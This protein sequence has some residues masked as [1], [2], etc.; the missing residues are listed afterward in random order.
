MAIDFDEELEPKVAL[1]ICSQHNLKYDPE[2]TWGCVL[3][4]ASR[5]KRISGYWVVAAIL[6]VAAGIYLLL[7]VIR[8]DTHPTLSSMVT[9]GERSTDEVS[10]ADAR[11]ACV[12]Q[13]SRNIEEC[14]AKID[15]A[16]ANARMDKEFC[17]NPL[18]EANDS[19][20]IENFGQDY[21]R[22]PL[23]N[24]SKI[25][26]WLKVRKVL[27][28][29]QEAIEK[30][31]DGS[32]YDFAVRVS[33]AKATGRSED[34]TLS[35]FGLDT[36]QRFCLYEFFESLQFPAVRAKPYT[37]VTHVQSGL[38]ALNRPQKGDEKGETFKKFVEEQ[39]NAQLTEKRNAEI[40]QRRRE[41]DKKFQSD[42]KKE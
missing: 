38:L 39:R 29:N 37:F 14:I 36:S 17:L 3:C 23:Y 40:M 25:P 10:E 22:E 8:P 33:V 27:E 21:L 24:I 6:A 7:P 9:V 13:L 12:L 30:C 16:N 18:Q 15:P 11:L 2:I 28:E 35:L 41:F 4:R 20:P 26:D 19:C 31:M 32:A 5:K 42:M 1:A 34:I